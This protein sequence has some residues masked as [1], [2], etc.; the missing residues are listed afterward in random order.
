MTVTD[1]A[2]L[3]HDTVWQGADLVRRFVD[4]VRGG[5]PHAAD[6]IDMMLRV[7]AARSVPVERFVDLGCGSGVLARAVLAHYPKAAAVLVDFSEPMLAEARTALA[8]HRPPPQFVRADLAGPA[9]R[10]AVQLA[11][12]F[13]LVVSGYAIHHLQDVRKRALYR[14]IHDL[15]A[16]GGFFLNVEHVASS[17]PW[18]EQVANDL[19]IDSLHAFHRSR[20]GT[21]T[22]AEVA[23]EFVHRPD[24]A[25]NIL[26][27]VEEQCDWLRQIGFEDVD[28]FFKVFELAVFGGRRRSATP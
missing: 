23:G 18:V 16:P 26:V 19:L 15:L 6:Q 21:K 20:G 13:D 14:E 2:T 28:C 22:R 17:T 4:D 8:T 25:A 3:R 7:V 24:K 11:A 9:W 12:P 1:D 27:L 5:V 10:D